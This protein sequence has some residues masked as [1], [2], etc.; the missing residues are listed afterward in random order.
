MTGATTVCSRRRFGDV[1]ARASGERTDGMRPEDHGIVIALVE[2]EPRD[3]SSRA[4]A[5]YQ[6]EQRV[7][8]PNPAGQAT[9]VSRRSDPSRRRPEGADVGSPDRERPAPVASCLPGSASRRPL[10]RQRPKRIPA[11][12]RCPVGYPAVPDGVTGSALAYSPRIPSLQPHR[13]A[14][15]FK[16]SRSTEEGPYS[17]DLGPGSARKRHGAAGSPDVASPGRSPPPA[18]RPRWPVEC[19]IEHPAVCD[20]SGACAIPCLTHRPIRK[21]DSFPLGESGGR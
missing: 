5:S 9:R 21:R 4:S 20:G 13:P 2:R 3:G 1:G 14:C 16:A 10:A 7:V 6:A 17:E 15:Q 19:G 18:P 11:V 12:Q 8:F